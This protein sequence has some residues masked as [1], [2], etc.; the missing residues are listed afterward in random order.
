[1]ESAIIKAAYGRRYKTKAEAEKDWLDGR[2]FF[3]VADQNG[4]ARYSYCSIRDFSPG[5]QIELRYGMFDEKVTILA[6]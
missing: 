2:D 1:M 3:M 5:D 4:P 6:V